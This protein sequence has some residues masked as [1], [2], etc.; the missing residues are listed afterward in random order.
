MNSSGRPSPTRTFQTPPGDGFIRADKLPYA[1]SV[2]VS[3]PQSARAAGHAADAQNSRELTIMS[4]SK[5][6]LRETFIQ[7]LW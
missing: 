4:R 5:R 1:L 6:V 2:V 7:G 3:S